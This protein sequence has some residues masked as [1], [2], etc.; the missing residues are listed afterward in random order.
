MLPTLPVSALVWFLLYSKQSFL[1][2][3]AMCKPL[4]SF[5]HRRGV[6]LPPSLELVCAA[7]RRSP[8]TGLV[9]IPQHDPLSSTDTEGA[10]GTE[11]TNSS[12]DEDYICGSQGTLNHGSRQERIHLHIQ[13][14]N[15]PQE[16][17]NR[18]WNGFCTPFL[19][20]SWTNWQ[21]WMQ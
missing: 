12:R 5:G 18:I 17:N 3:L 20:L 21:A 16:C 7:L 4:E 9:V 14:M 10:E 6:S 11:G 19:C 8:T 2:G 15:W 13:S 1:D